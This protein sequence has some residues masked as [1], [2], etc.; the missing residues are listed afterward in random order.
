MI[1]QANENDFLVIE[2]ILL[3]AVNWMKTNE[4]QNQWNENNIKWNSLSKE[5]KITDFYIN[6]WN[7]V[8]AACVAITDLDQKFWSEI[9]QGRSLYIHK[10]TVMREFAG[11]GLSKE[12][13][14]FA[15][16]LSL[17]RGI[18]SLRLDCNMQRDKLRKIYEK[19]G[20]KFASKKNI[21]NEHDMAL[22]VWQI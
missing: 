12:L 18:N 4:L 10:L 2:E 7:E 8:P 5:Y 3:D 22:Y 15:K 20:F 1:K 6:Y 21:K 9:P 11:K 19:E 16:N 17:N 14:D 13:I